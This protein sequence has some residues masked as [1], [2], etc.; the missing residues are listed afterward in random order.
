M[1]WASYLERV[2]GELY[3]SVTVNS[4]IRGGGDCWDSANYYG[5]NGDGYLI[6][7][8]TPERIGG[9]QGIPIESIRMKQ[10]RDGFEDHSWLTILE[11]ATSREHVLSFVRNFM[12]TPWDMDDDMANFQAVRLRI[13]R[14]IESAH[15]AERVKSD[16]VSTRVEPCAGE[17]L[18]NG[19][20][21]PPIW[22]PRR[23]LT[24]S[25]EKG[26]IESQSPTYLSVPP[27]VRGISV[28]RSLFVDSFLVDDSKTH[29]VTR[30]F[31]A[32]EYRDDINPVITFDRPW[33]RIG[34]TYARPFSGGITWHVPTRQYRLFYGC[35]DSVAGKLGDSNLALC[36]ATSADGLHWKK[37]PQPIVEGTNIVVN[38]PLRSNNLWDRGP[39]V[40]ERFVIADT[41]GPKYPGK[42]Y[43]LWG[44][45]DGINNWR[46]LKNVTGPTSARGTFFKDP[47]RKRWIFSIKGYHSWA[48]ADWGRHRMY[49]ETPDDDPFGNYSWNS[50]DPVMVRRK[51]V[52]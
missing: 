39:G 38:F 24:G 34:S 43:W 49:W 48:M 23:N 51:P 37:P 40:A 1:E 33:E 3:Y 42:F 21:L 16:D 8:G 20:C 15:R 45:P 26:L 5:G 6:Y 10:V 36:L 14:A 50:T 9:T 17:Q 18:H 47:F 2:D 28:G 30:R 32:A 29:G 4:K 52:Y 31:F 35:G 25:F 7:A 12:R 46:P 44:S 13:G 19:I 11:A 27:P 41:N 22:P